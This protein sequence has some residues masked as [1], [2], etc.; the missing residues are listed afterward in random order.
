[1]LDTLHREAASLIERSRST[2]S[3]PREVSGVTVVAEDEWQEI[4]AKSKLRVKNAEVSFQDSPVARIFCGRMRSVLSARGLRESV[5]FQPFFTLPLD[6]EPD[7]VRTVRDALDLFTSTGAVSGLRGRRTQ[8]EIKASQTTRL[9]RLPHALVLHLK[10]FSHCGTDSGTSKVCKS[11]SFEPELT[12]DVDAGAIHGAR[13]GALYALRAVVVHHG[14]RAEGGHYTAFVLRTLPGPLP[15]PAT[16]PVPLSVPLA[17]REV[18]SST[19][20]LPPSLE[21]LAHE[22]E[23]EK[24]DSL[25]ITRAAKSKSS[26]RRRK[27]KSKQSDCL[28]SPL[29]P[30]PTSGTSGAA[31]RSC[32]RCGPE[33]L[34]IDD[35]HVRRVPSETVF[36]QQA[37]LLFYEAINN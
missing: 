9:D 35:Q 2:S 22:G 17:V 26:R 33:W 37:Y 7:E 6:I 30:P 10:R 16:V 3:V 19:T 31:A 34:H 25:E 11:V 1:M 12:I 29:P 32:T 24:D 20:P 18:L 13:G 21:S 23:D 14:A 36:R 5:S 8:R 27:A 4:G 15:G 28:I